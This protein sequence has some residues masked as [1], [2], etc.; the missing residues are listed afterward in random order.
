MTLTWGPQWVSLWAFPLTFP[1]AWVLDL[2][3]LVDQHLDDSTE[4]GISALDPA[5]SDTDGDGTPDSADDID[6][7]TLSVSAELD[8]G[9]EI[10][11]QDTDDD[12]LTDGAEVKIYSTDPL[13]SDTDGDGVDDGTEIE[14]GT[15]PL[16][17]DSDDDG[18]T[19]DQETYEVTHAVDGTTFNVSVTGSAE[20]ATDITA[21]RVPQNT[22]ESFR[23]SDVV[24]VEN[25][26]AIDS[27]TVQFDVPQ[28]T[29]TTDK[30]NL[31]VLK[32]SPGNDTIWMPVNTTVDNGT[33]TAEVK[34]FSYFALVDGPGYVNRLVSTPEVDENDDDVT[35]VDT[36]LVVDT[37]GSMR[38]QKI[39][40]ARDA[41]RKF[42]DVLRDGDQGALVGFSGS[43]TTKQSMT[44]EL[45]DVRSAISELSAGGGTD[46]A[47]GIRE[48]RS[49]HNSNRIDDHE[50]VMVLLS[51]GKA[52][53]QPALD[54]A[55][56]AKNDGITIY[57][58]A[59]GSDADTD[60]LKKIAGRTDGEFFQV[61]DSGELT[62]TFRDI[63]DE[64][65]FNDSD[66][67]GLPDVFEDQRIYIPSGPDAGAVVATD[68]DTADTDDD[69]LEDGE[70]V[71][72]LSLD[73]IPELRRV[74]PSSTFEDGYVAVADSD[75]DDPN[76]DDHGIDDGE[77][78]RRGSNP[79]EKET[80]LMSGEVAT[81]TDSNGDPQTVSGHDG[82]RQVL[83]SGEYEW[84]DEDCWVLIW[85]CSNSPPDW[86]TNNVDT[87]RLTEGKTYYRVPAQ[88]RIY[89]EG[90]DV[91]NP[92]D[93]PSIVLSSAFDDRIMNGD[94]EIGDNRGTSKAL[95]IETDDNSCISGCISVETL[96][97]FTFR[98]SLP[99][100]SIFARDSGETVGSTGSPGQNIR[101]DSK[102]YGYSSFN[103]EVAARFAQ[104]GM[105][106]WKDATLTALNVYGGVYKKAFNPSGFKQRVAY[107]IA[108][109][110]DFRNQIRRGEYDGTSS[111]EKVE[112]ETYRYSQQ[113]GVAERYQ[114]FQFRGPGAIR[115]N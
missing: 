50:Q 56:A 114:Y 40:N 39:A 82:D 48:G 103:V 108:S 76:S 27:A 112:G 2:P 35:P 62:G 92:I 44:D 36:T 17:P 89:V 86:L 32:W 66:E 72:V 12:G 71:R 73:K 3:R 20:A 113:A 58:V 16:V 22:S 54:Q 42:V 21:E 45:G 97:T 81:I 98:G 70:E 101:T 28:G 90:S 24:R 14:V 60:L 69:G 107:R 31:T 51:D 80:L 74:A 85:A 33:A 79:F 67:D 104:E 78:K 7:D 88:I 64:V 13:N 111:T 5:D 37:S 95:I 29:S 63:G 93:D 25:R 94:V 115:E 87:D 102:R 110:K 49:E 10:G 11:L 57:T 99:P 83:I 75:P 23:R 100:G 4:R 47:A 15:G 55:D 84:G 18:V 105:E 91:E 46:I 96:G 41:S 6:G 38:G 30:E 106:T 8:N 65:K 19:D 77:E 1:S 109:G 34:D 43:A 61:D 53:Q 26:S 68:S 52:D 9:T 59:V